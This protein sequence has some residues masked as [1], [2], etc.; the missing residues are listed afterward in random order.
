MT[1]AH[2]DELLALSKARFQLEQGRMQTLL[3]EEAEIRGSLDRLEDSRRRARDALSCD[4]LAQGVFGGDVL[5]QAWVVRMRQDL[6]I[7]LAQVLARKGAMMRELARA[8]G[9]QTAAENLVQETRTARQTAERKT[10][11]EVL[12]D[13]FVLRAGGDVNR[14]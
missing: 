4:P 11:N 9:R 1:Q 13:L 3:A 5:W 2:L 6:Q 12:Q 10:Q 7:R 14:R 8:H